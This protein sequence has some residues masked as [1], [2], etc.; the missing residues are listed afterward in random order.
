MRNN[1]ISCDPLRC[2]VKAIY[3]KKLRGKGHYPGPTEE[4]K[5][6]LKG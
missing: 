1:G 4:L 6:K 3:T 2:P 5:Q